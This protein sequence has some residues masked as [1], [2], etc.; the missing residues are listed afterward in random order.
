MARIF[1]SYARAD[2]GDIANQLSHRLRA[3]EHEVFMDVESIRAGTQ[4]R[5]ELERRVKWSDLIVVIVTPGSNQS[6]Y[7]YEEVKQGETNK[8]R[9]FPIQVGDTPLPVHLRGTWQGIAVQDANLDTVLLEIERTL[10]ELPIRRSMNVY[11]LAALLALILVV[12]VL[13]AIVVNNDTQSKNAIATANA[14]LTQLAGTVARL[15]A[16][17]APTHTP[18]ASATNPTQEALE[19][20]ATETASALEAMLDDPT[21]MQVERAQIGATLTQAYFDFGNTATIVYLEYVMTLQA[22]TATPTAAAL[23]RT[24]TPTPAP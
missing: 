9:I 11:L 3:A 7:V 20:G 1:I 4:W 21:Q 8:K 24:A 17:A 23:A 6:D 22:L 10:K 14:G 2:G 16:T 18:K 5:R 13:A 19:R 12:A 15:T